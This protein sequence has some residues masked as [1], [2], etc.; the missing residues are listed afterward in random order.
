MS[1]FNRKRQTN[2]RVEGRFQTAVNLVKDLDK[3]EFKRLVKGM[4]LAWQ[5]YDAMRKV[6][7]IEEKG[8]DDIEQLEKAMEGEE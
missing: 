7:T 4:D 1:L 3:T 6:Q 2:D 5:A 8:L